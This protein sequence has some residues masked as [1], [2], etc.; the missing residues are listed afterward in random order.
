M[1]N[2]AQRGFNLIEMIIAIVIIGVAVSGVMAAFT[3]SARY[4]ADPVIRKQLLVAAEE[5][6]EEVQLK[7][8]ASAQA[9]TTSGCARG[10]FYKVSDYE[11]YDTTSLGYICDVDG[12]KINDLDGY[13]VVIRVTSGTL[14]SGVTAP[15]VK[16]TVTVTKGSEN[17]TL[18]GWR[19]SYA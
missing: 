6:M 3:Q 15:G 17:I 5:L 13:T 14:G 18:V 1:S 16:I 7:P 12:N 4:S 10:G 9:K 19:T 11:G 2:K 8:F